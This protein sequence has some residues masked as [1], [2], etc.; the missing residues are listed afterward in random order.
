MSEPNHVITIDF[1]TY[2]DSEYSLTKL[3][4]ATYVCSPQFEIIG[5]GWQLDDNEPEWLS[6]PM[7]VPVEDKHYSDYLAELPWDDAICTAHNA[8]FDGF[9]LENML[10]I[11]PR[12][13]FCTMMAARPVYN[14]LTGSVSL[15]ALS[16]HL[17]IGEKGTEVYEAK[18]KHR[19]DFSTEELEAYAEYCKTD[20]RLTYILYHTL[21]AWYE[22]HDELRA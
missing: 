20:V 19:D 18:G 21:T 12:R 17:G 2:Y 7:W 11:H 16:E 10:N 6:L 3:P 8:M 4:T 14:H 5:V 22:E 1:E 13:Y 9:I 15:K